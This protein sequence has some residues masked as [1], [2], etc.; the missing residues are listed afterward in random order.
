MNFLEQIQIGD[1]NGVFD[2]INQNP[3]IFG[4]IVAWMLTWKGL[5]LWKAARL[6]H[7][8]WFVI[9]LLANTLGILEIIYLFFIARKYTIEEEVEE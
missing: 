7:K 8:W 5:A 3:L 1:Q 6:S 2:F 9:I 4:L